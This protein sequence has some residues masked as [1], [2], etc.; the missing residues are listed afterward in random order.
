MFLLWADE[1]RYGQL[2]GDTRKAYSKGR[3]EYPDTVNGA[4]ELLVHTSRQ[5]GGRIIRRGR[6]SF[7]RGGRTSVMFTQTRGN[8]G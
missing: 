6:R 5:F 2:F 1:Y 4:Y 8:Q 3:D 7:R